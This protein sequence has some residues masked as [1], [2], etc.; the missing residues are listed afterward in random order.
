[1]IRLLSKEKRI[2]SLV[3]LRIFMME[4]FLERLS[5]SK[6]N[7]K[8]ILKG[9]LLVSSMIGSA[10]RSTMD[11]DMTIRGV[12]VDIG[13]IRRMVESIISITLFDGI[14]FSIR[15]VTTIMEEAEYAGVRVSMIAF[16]DNIRVPLKSDF[17]TGDEITPSP[18]KYQYE[19]MFENRSINLLSYNLETLLA[20]KLETVIARATTNTRM[21]DFYDIYILSVMFWKSINSNLLTEALHATSCQRGTLRMMTNAEKVLLDLQKNKNIQKLWAKYR[22]KL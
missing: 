6:Y 13:T 19:L 9:G 15:A 14:T 22:E 16:L 17:S 20:E 18:I 4:R 8:L 7:D 1:M 3:L 10:L 5:V 12:I 21:R 2:D 11:T